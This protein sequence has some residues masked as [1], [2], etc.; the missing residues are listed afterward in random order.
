[1]KYCQ[2]RASRKGGFFLDIVQELQR[3][4]L[5]WLMGSKDS[6]YRKKLG[7]NGWSFLHSP[8]LYAVHRKWSKKAYPEKP[9]TTHKALFSLYY[10]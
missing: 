7:G 2:K 3:G 9:S 8:F 5:R 10:I 6:M 1:V 4:R